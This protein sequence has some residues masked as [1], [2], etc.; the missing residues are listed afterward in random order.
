MAVGKI[1]KKLPHSGDGV[2]RKLEILMPN[3]KIITKSVFHILK[4]DQNESS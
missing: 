3:K 1:L 2:I 4:L